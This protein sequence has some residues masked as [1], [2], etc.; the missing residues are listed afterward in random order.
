[1]NHMD[2][3]QGY[4]HHQHAMAEDDKALGNRDLAK[5]AKGQPESGHACCG[6]CMLTSVVPLSP[7]ATVAQTVTRVTFS[8]PVEQLRGRIV[9]V[10]PDIPRAHRLI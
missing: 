3:H 9:F 5:V 8:P 7:D 1:M 6:A 10:D 4:E 2:S